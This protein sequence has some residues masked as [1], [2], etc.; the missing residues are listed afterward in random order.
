[1]RDEAARGLWDTELV[2]EYFSMLEL[3]RQVA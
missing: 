2:D 3:K 1:M